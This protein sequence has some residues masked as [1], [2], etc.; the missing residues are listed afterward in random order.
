MLK[1]Q[2]HGNKAG[3][4]N[5]VGEARWKAYVLGGGDANPD[6]NVVKG[7]FLLNNH[8]AFIPFDSGANRS[9]VSTTFNMLLDITPDTLDVSYAVKLADE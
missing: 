3:N 8:Y 5:G 6:F 7:I 2:N 4:K 9:F 1:D